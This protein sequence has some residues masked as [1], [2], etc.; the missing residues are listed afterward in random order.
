MYF[1]FAAYKNAVI[2]RNK[3]ISREFTPPSGVE[4]SR[5]S[6]GVHLSPS[7]IIDILTHLKYRCAVV[8]GG[9]GSGK[10]ALSRYFLLEWAR[11]RLPLKETITVR[12][13]LSRFSGDFTDNFLK[14]VFRDLILGEESSPASRHEWLK[15]YS[16]LVLCDNAEVY[17]D[18][19]NPERMD[20][21]LNDFFKKYPK[22]KLVLIY[23]I[24]G[25]EI[26]A[27]ENIRSILLK[28]FDRRQ[29]RAF[30][31]KWANARKLLKHPIGRHDGLLEKYPALDDFYSNP[32]FLKSIL[33]HLPELPGNRPEIYRV[34]SHKLLS[35]SGF[36]QKGLW[37]RVVDVGVLTDI[38]S[39][40]AFRITQ[41]NDPQRKITENELKNIVSE[42]LKLY[43]IDDIDIKTERIIASFKKRNLFLS[44]TS[45]RHFSFILP[46]FQDYY[47]AQETVRRFSNRDFPEG[48]GFEK[49]K[50]IFID[51]HYPDHRRHH[52]LRLIIGMIPVA[53]AEKLI[54]A[55]IVSDG[56]KTDFSNIFLAAACISEIQCRGLLRKLS[57]TVLNH[58]ILVAIAP[59]DPDSGGAKH[60]LRNIDS[61]RSRAVRAIVEISGRRTVTASL[62]KTMCLSDIPLAAKSAAIDAVAGGWEE[63]SD[64]GRWLIRQVTSNPDIS[65]RKTMI[66]ALG[67]E[68]DASPELLNCFKMLA[69]SDPAPD[70]R[71]AALE[72]IGNQAPDDPE[73]RVLFRQSMEKA[74]KRYRKCGLRFFGEH[75][76]HDSRFGNTMATLLS[77]PDPELRSETIRLWSESISDPAD[78]PERFDRIAIHDKSPEVRREALKSVCRLSGNHDDILDLC[79]SLFRDDPDPLVR[80]LAL[81]EMSRLRPETD[82][83][84]AAALSDDA[85]E[86]RKT[87]LGLLTE[88]GSDDSDVRSIL[89]N[90]LHMDKH[91]E[92]RCQAL[93]L[94][95]NVESDESTL[96]D[97]IRSMLNDHRL[98]KAS[99][100]RGLLKFRHLDENMLSIVSKRLRS[101]DFPK[102]RQAALTVLSEKWP[103]HPDVETMIRESA[104][105]DPHWEIRRGA[106]WAWTNLNHRNKDV[107]AWLKNRATSDSHWP[108]RQMAI[109]EALRI[110]E[111]DGLLFE[112]L[113]DRA[114]NDSCGETYETDG[115]VNPR[116]TALIGMLTHYP[117]DH[118][119]MELL[120]DRRA[121]DPD[122]SIRLFA[123]N[124]LIIDAILK[125][126][127]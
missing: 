54:E 8:F 125:D 18:I 53:Y 45:S 71:V 55:L 67:F 29:I 61:I 121:K 27:I 25:E 81:T 26:P 105:T 56:N 62:L 90:R 91:P 38:F 78:I 127:A 44:Y 36:T 110:G 12:I 17:F 98:L 51:Y 19:E 35:R 94:I 124:I 88:K 57:N 3:K 4:L 34:I 31:S 32:L 92:V 74:D 82:M 16:V 119:T 104:E 118:R 73:T 50:Q 13:D 24:L 95:F 85:F 109:R 106:I 101:D 47:Y 10:T 37:P 122:P 87:A 111:K 21:I 33:R 46:I 79:R 52:A 9:A 120:Y 49:L 107:M 63:R 43:E 48:I 69:I 6:P 15:N 89:D 39:K 76:S 93:K 14:E 42:R 23:R 123:R 28:P 2:L 72:S 41:N 59:I 112:F 113:Y 96:W 1:D 86:I 65:L 102:V 75:C 100:I 97:I 84:K 103:D 126:S 99:A 80:I 7:P 60:F 115:L 83:L 40:I 77:D 66:R 108:V 116:L 70:I 117:W 68:W 114:I 5:L 20:R 30:I 64:I 58:L 22:I 11:G